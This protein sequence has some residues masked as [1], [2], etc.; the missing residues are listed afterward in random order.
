MPY[1]FSAYF[2]TGDNE[3]G[4]WI[5][6]NERAMNVIADFSSATPFTYVVGHHP[7]EDLDSSQLR[8]F[9]PD[10]VKAMP[11]IERKEKYWFPSPYHTHTVVFDL[12]KREDR[13]LIKDK[14]SHIVR[15]YD[16]NDKPG[17]LHHFPRKQ[18]L[19][20]DDANDFENAVKEFRMEYLSPPV[21][22]LFSGYDEEVEGEIILPKTPWQISS[23]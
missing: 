9:T 15:N 4:E 20:P 3:N 7:N 12:E 19:D 11:E 22:V 17:F 8:D 21:S 14:I 5:I 13:I 23:Y 16:C 2:Y 1:N 18:I 6:L 10:Y